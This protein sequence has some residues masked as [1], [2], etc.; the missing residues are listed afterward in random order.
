MLNV[1]HSILPV[2]SSLDSRLNETNS[3]EILQLS[4]TVHWGIFEI[5]LLKIPP[6]PK[7]QRYDI[8]GHT[9]CHYRPQSLDDNLET[10]SASGIHYEHLVMLIPTFIFF[11]VAGDHG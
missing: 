2:V 11:F 3:T 6:E 10:K 7:T 1:F 8:R 9:V 4:F 5:G